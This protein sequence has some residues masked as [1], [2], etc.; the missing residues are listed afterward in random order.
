LGSAYKKKQKKKLNFFSLQNIFFSLPC[1][2]FCETLLGSKIHAFLSFL[3]SNSR[4]NWDLAS[5]A[6]MNLAQR[7]FVGLRRWIE[8][9]KTI[10][11][12]AKRLGLFILPD[13]FT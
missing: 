5:N 12:E 10:W 6:E 3:A 8:Y 11:S 13:I 4:V 1:I 2:D 9:V 7:A